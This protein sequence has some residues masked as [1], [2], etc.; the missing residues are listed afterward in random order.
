MYNPE[1]HRTNILLYIKS[2][3]GLHFDSTF[4]YIQ[5]DNRKVHMYRI[6]LCINAINAS[7]KDKDKNNDNNNKDEKG[8]QFIFSPY[9]YKL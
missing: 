7:D 5:G 2:Q 4:I 8:V 1:K 6:Y 3:T 9:I